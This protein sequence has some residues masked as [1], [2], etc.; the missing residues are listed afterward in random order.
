MCPEQA[1]HCN[2]PVHIVGHLGMYCLAESSRL[3]EGGAVITPHTP[4]PALYMDSLRITV[5]ELRSRMAAPPSSSFYTMLVV[6][7]RLPWQPVRVECVATDFCHAPRPSNEALDGYSAAAVDPCNAA[8][9]VRFG[10][11]KFCSFA[12][13]HIFTFECDCASEKATRLG[14]RRRNVSGK[15]GGLRSSKVPRWSA[16]ES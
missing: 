8:I 3:G 16:A 5:D 15:G 2:L 7:Q 1:V 14:N 13:L 4:R 9:E 6:S 10:R 12:Q 11:L